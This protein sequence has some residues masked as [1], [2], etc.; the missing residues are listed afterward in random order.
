MTELPGVVQDVQQL[1]AV[2]VAPGVLRRTL[3][4]TDELTA[5]IIDFAPGSR[6]PE[7]DEHVGEER[8]FVLSGAVVEGD[9][10]VPAGSYVTMPAGSSH[11]PSSVVGARILGHNVVPRTPPR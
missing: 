8:Y 5:W 9:V 11:Q 3:Y 1:P 2:E 10:E 4:S 7:V 6:W